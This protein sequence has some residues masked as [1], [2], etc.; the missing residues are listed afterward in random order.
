[1]YC[2][3]ARDEESTHRL[4]KN[5]R[6]WHQALVLSSHGS[7]YVVHHYNACSVPLNGTEYRG[8]VESG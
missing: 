2:T 6:W 5:S 8:S 3:H 1:M 7:V 4:L